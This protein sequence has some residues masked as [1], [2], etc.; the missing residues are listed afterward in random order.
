MLNIN[1]GYP[2]L[3]VLGEP[4]KSERRIAIVREL[5]LERMLLALRVKLPHN[6]NDV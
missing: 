1:R 4:H 3:I 5:N 6:S 2:L